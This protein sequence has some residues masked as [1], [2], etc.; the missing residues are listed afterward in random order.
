MKDLKE[1]NKILEDR[2]L[3]KTSDFALTNKYPETLPK[4]KMPNIN[5]PTTAP[6]PNNNLTSTS[7][8]MLSGVERVTKDEEVYGLIQSLI[9][10]LIESKR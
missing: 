7:E 5:N 1:K 8:N 2:L 10:K 4:K 9:Y 6:K 3:L